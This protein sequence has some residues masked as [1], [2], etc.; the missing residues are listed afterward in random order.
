MKKLIIPLLLIVIY[1]FATIPV[2]HCQSIKLVNVNPATYPEVKVEFFGYDA[3]GV[4]IRNYNVNDIVIK[5]DGIKR[6]LLWVDCPPEDLSRFSLILVLDLSGSMGDPVDP[7]NDYR[8][9][10]TVARNAIRSFIGNLPVGRFE[11]AL[12]AFSVNSYLLCDFTDDVSLLIQALDSNIVAPKSLTDYNAAFLYDVYNNPGA[13]QI[14]EHAKYKPFIIF[15]TDGKHE[16]RS[17]SDRYEVWMPQIIDKTNQLDATIFSIALNL[18]QTDIL[19]SLAQGPKNK[20]DVFGDVNQSTIDQV[21][22]EILQKIEGKGITPPCDLVFETDCNGGEMTMEIEKI[23]AST[24]KTYTISESIKPSLEVDPRNFD[25]KNVLP[26][27]SPVQDVTITARKNFVNVTGQNFLDSRIQVVDWGGSAPPFKLDKD[28]SRKIKI[29]Y[30][31]ND[32]SYIDGTINLASSACSGNDIHPASAWIYLKDVDMGT[33]TLKQTKEREVTAVF[34]NKSGKTIKINTM[35]IS[36]L[37]ATE[38]VMI[39]PPFNIDLPNDSCL[40][41]TFRFTPDETGKR[42]AVFTINTSEGPYNSEIFGI[43]SGKASIESVSSINF[44]PADCKNLSYEQEIEIKNP[45]ALPLNIASFSIDNSA[46]TFVPSNPGAKVIDPNESIKITIRFEPTTPGPNTGNLT[47]VS[48][49]D[50]SPNLVIPLNGSKLEHKFTTSVASID[51][52]FA[53]PD[54]VVEKTLEIE[55]TGNA[56]LTINAVVS[57]PFALPVNNWTIP[58][59]EKV[60]VVIYYVAT[61]TGSQN[62][63]FTDNYCNFSK[64]L[65]LAG[66]LD[67]VFL[68]YDKL[69]IVASV[70]SSTDK[71]VNVKNDTKRTVTVSACIFDDA[72]FTLVSPTPPFDIP[73]GG[74]KDITVKYSPTNSNEINTKLTLNGSPCDFTYYVDLQGLPFASTAEIEISKYS[75]LIGQQIQIPVR[76]TNA[77]NLDQSGTNA[78]NFDIS[79]SADLLRPIAPTP[80]GTTSA[81]IT[82]ISFT[83]QSINPNAGNQV[84]VTLNFEVLATDIPCTDISINNESKANG[85]LV[86]NKATN[87]EFCQIPASARLELGSISAKPGQKV[88]LPVYLKNAQNVSDFH[89]FIN[90][91]LT[92]NGYLLD[93]V[94]NVKETVTNGVRTISLQLPVKP[95]NNDGL[96]KTLTFTAML[97]NAVSTDLTLSNIASEK[98]KI[99]FQAVNGLFTLDGV[100]N[101]GKEGES[102]RLFNPNGGIPLGLV[103]APNPA[104]HGVTVYFTL[105]EEGLTEIWISDV[106]GN[107]AMLITSENMKIGEYSKVVDCINLTTGTY[108]VILKTPTATTTKRLDIVK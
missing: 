28:A 26:G 2:L 17:T 105:A 101:S 59:G 63:V 8:S 32:T 48:D 34:C 31:A 76:L 39:N 64:S 55:N 81:G 16:F 51:F 83:N 43:G 42:S 90:A 37:N 67:P 103:L 40:T 5:E 108:F 18:E 75:A 36:G 94:E 49:A 10:L 50:N 41:I 79:F 98:G 71:I 29:R 6:K 68:Q 14:A 57:N 12:T 54:E 23:S 1:F 25:F 27:E 65:S 88:D 100:C 46:F 107:K 21:Y 4:N 24:S 60:Q 86:I 13:L 97:G 106:L 99:N 33:Q 47:I 96:L 89:Q 45:G 11:C 9:R 19:V 93:P 58:A 30:N 74:N 91:D 56:E 92:M 7:P 80:G 78:L 3:A 38:F 61:A 22:Q 15:L 102:P 70:G 82:T 85:Y 84:I 77:Q 35:S 53:C 87:G 69:S 95:L 66:T 44:E 52:G 20:G 72:Q 104:N 73:A 62:I